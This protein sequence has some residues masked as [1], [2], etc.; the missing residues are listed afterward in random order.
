MEFDDNIRSQNGLAVCIRDMGN[1]RSRLFI[2][3]V[4]SNQNM[5]P[6]EWT[7]ETFYTFT[8]ELEN[9]KIEEMELTEKEFANIGAA[10]V[11]RLLAQRGST[12]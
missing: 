6:I 11:A 7:Y 9:T 3:D 1:G 4:I 2:D 10:V 12:K 8:P 5:N